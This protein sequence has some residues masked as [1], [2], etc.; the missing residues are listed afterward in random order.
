MATELLEVD[1]EE[2]ARTTPESDIWAFAMTILEA[3]V[4]ICY[5]LINALRNDF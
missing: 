3:G 1:G 2:P 4:P 5:S